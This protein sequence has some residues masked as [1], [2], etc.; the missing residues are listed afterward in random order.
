MKHFSKK[1]ST[2]L[3]ASISLCSLHAEENQSA[4][5]SILQFNIWNEARG[6][7][8][9]FESIVDEII[10]SDADF[11]TLS[12]V[13]NYGENFTKK[14]CDEIEKKSG[15][16]FFSFRSDDS[17][18]LSSHPIA[19]HQTV[20]PLSDDRGSIYK[21][22][23][24]IA[25]R[26]VALYTAHLDYTHYPCYYPRGY[27]GE[28]W[29]KLDAPITD[30]CA[31]RKMNLASRRDEQIHAFINDANKE[32]ELGSLI[33]LGGDF[34]EPSHLDWGNNTKDVFDHNGVVYQWDQSKALSDHDFIDAYREVWPDAQTHP[35]ITY[36]SDNPDQAINSLTWAPDADERDRIDFI[37]HGPHKDLRATNAQ[38][39]GP[40]G[41]ISHNQRVGNPGKDSIVTPLG[42]WPSDHKAVLVEFTL[43]NADI[44][45]DDIDPLTPEEKKEI[46][47]AE[48]NK[49]VETSSAKEKICYRIKNVTTGQY[50]AR[51]EWKTPIRLISADEARKDAG[52]Y[53]WFEDGAE[54]DHKFIIR[55]YAILDHLD[56][57]ALDNNFK[58]NDGTE[59]NITKA[60]S[61]QYCKIG[62]GDSDDYD[63]TAT[64]EGIFNKKVVEDPAPCLWTLEKV[65]PENLPLPYL[66][67]SDAQ[68]KHYYVM[69]NRQKDQFVAAAP[70]SAQGAAILDS[71]QNNQPNQLWYFESIENQPQDFYI[72]NAAYPDLYFNGVGNFSFGT[73][74]TVWNL[75]LSEADNT[76]IQ[77]VEKPEI[78]KYFVF[79]KK[80]E[81]PCLS[82][83]HH[84]QG[85]ELVLWNGNNTNWCDTWALEEVPVPTG[86]Q[87]LASP[88]VDDYIYNIAG[89]RIYR[90][91]P[92]HI[93]IKNGK[94]FLSK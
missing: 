49:V 10:R 83:S 12:E 90:N 64:S 19:K 39:I 14:L 92:Q 29:Q 58:N 66:K 88:E 78:K 30:T 16:R 91:A 38:L 81:T 52:A 54:K 25:G 94:K 44:N 50:A 72:K 74:K 48:K 71:Y 45:A 18:L 31:I 79:R 17:G 4:K 61:L 26:R 67:A 57:Y 37:Y 41:T 24:Q 93:Y 40:R 47:M 33:F 8:G 32:K 63:W 34:N 13:R 56:L 86:I 65:E 59:W 35:G 62:W 28:N 21:A 85:A 1:I 51:D 42:I 2:L 5:F 46:E 15:K 36:P 27:N 73:E 23:T 84:Q 89:Q 87:E 53:W 68:E 43:N 75:Q 22:V 80:G 69:L 76:A 3:L 9:G 20:F 82:Y 70:A 7:N 77:N 55:N 6:I 60:D 11:I